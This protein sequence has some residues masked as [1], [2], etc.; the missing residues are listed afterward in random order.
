MRLARLAIGSI[1]ALHPH[2]RHRLPPAPLGLPPTRTSPA[3]PLPR[4]LQRHG[5]GTATLEWA[6][7]TAEQQGALRKLVASSGLYRL[8]VPSAGAG[9]P[10]VAA[11]FPAR[12]LAAAAADGGL[13]LDLLDAGHVAGIALNA[14]CGRA[15]PAAAELQL[16]ASQALAVRLPAAAPQVLP[17]LVPGQVAGDPSAT[18]GGAGLQQEAAG[19]GAGAGGAAGQQAAG[20][21]G[22]AGR[23]GPGKGKPQPDERTWLQK[24]WMLVLPLGFIVSWERAGMRNAAG[25]A[26]ARGAF[27]PAS[28][29][30][31]WA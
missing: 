20:A 1:A 2:R 22:A 16:P 13:A 18:L 27:L 7:L 26:Q 9:T 29:S 31:G 4:S 10:P 30:L 25:G 12:C 23:Q 5:G 3:L 28:P 17:P 21:G 8:R 19:A 14:P 6:P 15:A 24:N 11:S